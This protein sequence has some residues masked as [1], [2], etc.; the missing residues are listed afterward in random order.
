MGIM[1]IKNKNFIPCR[2]NSNIN[3]KFE[4]KQITNT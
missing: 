1:V 3:K 2:N 4:I